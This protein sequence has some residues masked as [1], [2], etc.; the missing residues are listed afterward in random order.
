MLT[1]RERLYVLRE[2]VSTS[3]TR[4]ASWYDLWLSTDNVD[5]TRHLDGAMLW[6]CHAQDVAQEG[7]VSYGFDVKQGC[8][9]PA[10]PETTGYII[11]TF[12]DYVRHC[13]GRMECHTLYMLR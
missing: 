7:G 5:L 3:A 1:L 4:Q 9:F 2:I 10:Y 11:P 13:G 6:L 12:L 8:W